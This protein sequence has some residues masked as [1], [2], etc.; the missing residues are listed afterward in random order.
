MST[1]RRQGRARKRYLPALRLALEPQ[2]RKERAVFRAERRARRQG[3]T[4]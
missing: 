2:L 4:S 3:A 1:Y